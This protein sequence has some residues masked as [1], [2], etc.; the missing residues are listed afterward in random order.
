MLRRLGQVFID[1]GLGST[2]LYRNELEAPL[3]AAAAQQLTDMSVTWLRES[4]CPVYL[5][6]VES[7]LGLEGDRV[8]RLVCGCLFVRLYDVVV[9]MMWWHP[10]VLSCFFLA[11]FTFQ[12]A[13]VNQA[14]S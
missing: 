1:V 9:C 14:W 8:K 13:V 2:K 6:R 5:S 7:Q 4:S 3:L 11:T 10:F 12:L